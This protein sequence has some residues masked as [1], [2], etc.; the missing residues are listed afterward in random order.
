MDDTIFSKDSSLILDCG[1]G[2]AG[3]MVK[4]FG[5]EKCEQV[6]RTLKGIYASHLHAD[7]H[8]GMAGV[9]LA[10]AEAFKKIGLE[11]PKLILLLPNHVMPFITVRIT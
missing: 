2:T 4:L 1:E 8:I 11:A 5:L 10:R 9:I 6:L 3:Q 7:H